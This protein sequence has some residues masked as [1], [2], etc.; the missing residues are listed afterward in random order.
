MADDELTG[1]CS[2]CQNL[3]HDLLTELRDIDAVHLLLTGED[4]PFDRWRL[5]SELRT[6]ELIFKEHYEEIQIL[7]VSSK[8][9]G[10]CRVIFQVCNL[11]LSSFAMCKKCRFTPANSGCG[12]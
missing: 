1:T 7:L 12:C 4:P 6:H 5:D 3:I 9:C 11:C 8:V 10:V 2:A